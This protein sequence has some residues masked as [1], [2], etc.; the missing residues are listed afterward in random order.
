MRVNSYLTH[1]S[2]KK[3]NSKHSQVLLVFRKNPRKWNYGWNSVLKPCTALFVDILERI[4][5]FNEVFLVALTFTEQLFIERPLQRRFLHN[6]LPISSNLSKKILCKVIDFK[7]FHLSV[8]ATGG[9]LLEK[10]FLDIL[11][12]L[13]ENNCGKVSFLIKLQA[14]A[15]ASDISRVFSWRFFVYFIL[16]TKWN[17][18]REIPGWSWNIYFFAGVSL[19]FTLKISKEIG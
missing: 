6:F 10:V 16:T 7:I 3:I 12:N 13:Q 9:V 11:Q 2:Q 1:C 4:C 8:A 14:E 5:C 19:C 15:T 17:E 18:K